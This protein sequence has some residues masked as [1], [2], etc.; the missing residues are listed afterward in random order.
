MKRK[1]LTKGAK[2]ESFR[3][4]IIYNLR[5]AVCFRT[6]VAPSRA[7]SVLKK[8]KRGKVWRG[9]VWESRGRLGMWLRGSI[10]AASE[11]VALQAKGCSGRAVT[12]IHHMRELKVNS[13][14]IFIDQCIHLH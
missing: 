2:C 7:W 8:E 3:D 6:A 5:G 1:D 4:R 10:K 9:A 13:G 11:I 14:Y 12:V